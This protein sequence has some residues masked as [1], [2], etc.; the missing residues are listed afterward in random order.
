MR[1][2]SRLDKWLIDSEKDGVGI[3]RN[4]QQRQKATEENVA[5]LLMPFSD[6]E[7]FSITPVVAGAGKAV[8][9]LVL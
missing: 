6:G 4:D 1:Q 5:T 8:E 3:P 7:V 9:F 2:L